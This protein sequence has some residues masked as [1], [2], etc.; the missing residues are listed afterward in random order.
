MCL[1]LAAVGSSVAG[2]TRPGA[3]SSAS[4]SCPVTRPN[5]AAPP[6]NGPAKYGYRHGGL[7]VELWPFGVTLVGKSDVTASGSLGVKIP[8]YRYG[9]GSLNIRATRL[10]KPAP[11]A[12]THIPSGYG[13]TGFQSS[14]VY[15][16]SEGCWKIVGTAGHAQLAFVTIV[17]KTQTVRQEVPNG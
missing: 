1:A 15:F 10:D 7:W 16:P 14:A 12:R 13:S 6:G 9:K 8:W 4:P 3:Q 11:P 5:D 2:T 17:L